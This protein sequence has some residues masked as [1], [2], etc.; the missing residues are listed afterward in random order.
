MKNFKKTTLLVR[1]FIMLIILVLV[2]CGSGAP[3]GTGEDQNSNQ[4]ESGET[5]SAAE[6]FAKGMTLDGFSYDYVI[7]MP[8]GEKL[9]HKMW[10]KGG[11]MRSEMENPGGGA[12]TLSIINMEEDMVYIYQQ[13]TNFAM[14]M[15]IKESDVD[16]TSPK[17][18]FNKSD[19]EGLLFT[20]R[21]IFDNKECLVY[22]TNYEGGQGK[23]WI[24][25]EGGMPLRVE[26]T[27]GT[28]TIIVEFLNFTIGN[29]DD[30]MFQ[31]PAGVQIMDM[32]N[33]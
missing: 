23:I 27:S 29:I 10:V 32:S 9:T 14:Q 7:T 16:T 11:N 8:T 13:E 20:S 26:T 25:E 31:L 18:Y 5:I 3:E 17:D 22:E 2:G 30:S 33:Y 12:P 6:L 28:E 1:I 21:E 4:P 24:W 19:P 15:P